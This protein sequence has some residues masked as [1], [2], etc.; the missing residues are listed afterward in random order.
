M[1][2]RNLNFKGLTPAWLWLGLITIADCKPPPLPE[3]EILEPY[4]ITAR[5]WSTCQYATEYWAPIDVV[6]A[7]GPLLPLE[8]TKDVSVRQGNRKYWWYAPYG[9]S[10]LK[11]LCNSANTH[12]IANTEAI[13][14]AIKK[15]KTD[16]VYQFE[17][18]LVKVTLGHK[19]VV[20]S[21]SRFDEGDGSC[22]VLLVQ[23]LT[24]INSNPPKIERK[25][26]RN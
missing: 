1:N 8:S 25:K 20:S 9:V 18:S 23:K 13:R 10:K 19:V 24:K 11:V 5:V 14:D 16:E 17:G 4:A 15:I 7:W 26:S 6:L 22:E 3:I 12:L 2:R 21:L